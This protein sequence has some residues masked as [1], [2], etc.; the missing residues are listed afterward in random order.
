VAHA[1][2]MIVHFFCLPAVTFDFLVPLTRLR[3]PLISFL[4]LRVFFRSLTR[5]L[6]YRAQDLRLM[7]KE[8]VS[9]I[10]F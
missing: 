2:E 4:A 7:L 6:A 3:L 10:S 1:A 8:I 5:I 9:F